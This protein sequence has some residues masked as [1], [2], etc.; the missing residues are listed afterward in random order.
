MGVGYRTAGLLIGYYLRRGFEA[1]QVT[2]EER[3]LCRSDVGESSSAGS[4]Y[5]S[6]GVYKGSV[7][8]LLSRQKLPI[9]AWVLAATRSPVFDP[10]LR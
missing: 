8:A 5:H 1:Q 2:D 9:F 7:W 4:A 10:Q 6:S 3:T